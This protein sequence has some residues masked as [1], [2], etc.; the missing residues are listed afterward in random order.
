MCKNLQNATV[1]QPSGQWRCLPGTNH[2]ILPVQITKFTAKRVTPTWLLIILPWHNSPPVGQGLFIIQDSWSHS[3]TSHS[4]GL[5][6]TSNAQRRDIYL[7]TQHSRQTYMS[8]L[9]FETTNSAGQRSQH[10]VLDRAEIGT[11]LLLTSFPCIPVIYKP[12]FKPNLYTSCY[13][14]YPINSRTWKVTQNF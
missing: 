13:I 5:L 11:G 7:T 6:W 9:G 14:T 12:K 1:L 10:H 8:P 4:V 3:D 2:K